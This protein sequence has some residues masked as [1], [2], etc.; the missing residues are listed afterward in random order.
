MGTN[1]TFFVVKHS[2]YHRLDSRFICPSTEVFGTASIIVSVAGTQVHLDNNRVQ[3][4][5]L[6]GLVY[7]S[8]KDK[9]ISM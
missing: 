7:N 4:G 2:F 9:H 8:R 1:R 6:L 5:A 3:S